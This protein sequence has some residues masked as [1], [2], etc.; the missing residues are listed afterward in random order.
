MSKGG[1]GGTTVQKADPW[2]G[3]QPYLSY[4]FDQAKQQY[5]SGTPSYYP[6]STVAGLSNT[7]RLAQGLQTRRALTGNALANASQ[8]QLVDTANGNYLNGNPYLDANFRAGSDAISQAYGD[9]LRNQ[10]ASFAGSGRTGSGMQDFAIDRANDTLAKNLGNLYTQ[11]YYNNYQNER[12]NQMN[13]AQLAPTYAN[14][15]IANLNALS[16]VGT[17]QDTYSQNLLNADIDKWNYDQNLQK[18]KLADYMN[19]IQGNY[20]GTT[21]QTQKSNGGNGLGQALST[22]AT[23]ASIIAK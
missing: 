3:Q 9:T 21:T 14:M 23:A 20:G 19:M 13:A 5:E 17:A 16:D 10:T 2:S 1:G 11:T 7:T 8:N 15:D 22:A 12:G 18:N 6:N 4:G